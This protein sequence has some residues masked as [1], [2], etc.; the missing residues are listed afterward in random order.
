M[1]FPSMRVTIPPCVVGL[2]GAKPASAITRI[3]SMTPRVVSCP[4]ISPIS[5][6]VFKCPILCRTRAASAL[7]QQVFTLVPVLHTHAKAG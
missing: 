5:V 4:Y 2:V 1:R 7:G 6:V 3:E